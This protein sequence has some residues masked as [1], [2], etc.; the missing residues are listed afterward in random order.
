[1][2]RLVIGLVSLAVSMLA[3]SAADAQGTV[4]I[5]LILPYSGQF[6]DTATQMDNG[7]KLYLKKH[8]DTV[9]GKKVEIIRKDAG[10][11]SPDVAK[12]LAQELVVR[13]GVDILAGF[14]LTPNALAASDVSDQAKKFMVIMNAA[15]SIITTKSNYSVRT[16]LTLP[17]VT[18]SLGGWAYKSGVRKTYTMVS[19][20]GP[21]HDAE[22]GFQRAFKAAGGEIVGSVRFPLA[23]PDFSAFVQR[24]KDLN[25]ESIFIFVPG[26]AQPAALGK[27]LAE[28]GIDPKKIKVLGTGEVTDETAVRNMGDAALDI[29]TAWHYDYNHDSALNKEFVREF[30]AES[31][32]N[33]NFFAVGGYDGMHLIYEA[34]KKTSG[35]TDGDSLVNAAKGMKWESPRGP[36]S[37]DP[38]TRDIIQTVYIRRVQKVGGNLVNVEFDKIENVKDPVKASMKK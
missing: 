25:P 21:G 3:A 4:K 27:A 28:R 9:A 22:G 1:M 8:G 14:V 33:P 18:E 26:G 29:I 11:P 24:A 15:T 6:A 17:Q 19:D 20:Y 38:E 31:K 13:D 16:S 32:V 30:A 10:G 37:I 2:R 7:I 35:K 5:G 34:L 12:R 36:V 23:N